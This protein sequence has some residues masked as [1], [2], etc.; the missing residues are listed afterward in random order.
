MSKKEPQQGMKEVVLQ[1]VLPFTPRGIKRCITLQQVYDYLSRGLTTKGIMRVDPRIR[2]ETVALARACLIANYPHL[3]AALVKKAPETE[4]K[5]L[6]DEN[7]SPR[8]LPGLC[9]Y[10][11]HLTHTGFEKLNGKKDSEVW[12]WA[13]NNSFDAILTHDMRNKSDEDLTYIAVK[14]AMGIIEKE[15][16]DKRERVDLSS[17]PLVIHVLPDRKLK[18]TLPQLIKSFR[19]AVYHYLENRVSPYIEIS[20]HGVSC[21][22]TYANLVGRKMNQ[23]PDQVLSREER[24]VIDWKDKIMKNRRAGDLT[25]DQ[26]KNIDEMVRTAAQICAQTI[27]PPDDIVLGL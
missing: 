5:V 15:A 20:Y 23:T 25:P 11:R 24:W 22:L 12:R 4:Y 9:D 6:V 18:D 16:S 14:E 27:R 7:I 13:V 8:V 2:P 3:Y 10:F 19:Q 1:E 26:E 17:L 21:G